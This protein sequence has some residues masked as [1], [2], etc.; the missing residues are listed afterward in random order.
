MIDPLAEVVTLLQPRTQFAK[1]VLAASPWRLFSAEMHEPFYCAVL[2]GG[3]H[4]AIDDI[5][6]FT[7]LAG[8]FFLVPSTGGITMTSLNAPPPGVESAPPVAVG[9]GEF[10]LGARDGTV[11][12]RIAVGHCTFG[13][14]D[15]SLLLSLLPRLI[16]VRGE[17]RLTTLVQMIRDETRQQRPAREVVL[18]RL[19]E[20]LLIEALRSGTEG[21]A[22]QGLIRGLGDARL[23]SALRSMHG[24]PTHAWT[25][26]ALAKEAA[27]SRTTFFE[28]FQ[29]ALGVT[30]MD[31][32][33]AWRMALAK[34]MLRRKEGGVAEVAARV[35]YGSAST[36]SVAFTRHVGLPPSHFA[37][38]ADRASEAR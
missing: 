21:S 23:A 25:V 6:P 38:D 9:K 10:H 8:D 14:P 13:S 35:G 26:A 3:C 12:T 2:E 24:R 33:L 22:S 1:V 19:I 17:P 28:R 4:V 20:L 30:P 34:D 16:H 5:E 29:R 11:D 32:L 36:F 15:A 31:Y 18:A 37:R 27:L 7:V